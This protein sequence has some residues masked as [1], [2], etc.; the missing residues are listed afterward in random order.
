M[1]NFYYQLNFDGNSYT[2]MSY[3]G[4]EQDVKIPEVYGGRPVTVLFDKLFDGH[5]EIRS[6]TIPDVVTDMGEFI[7]D[8]CENITELKLPS[9]L[10]TLWGHTFVR[11]NIE[12]IVIPDGVISI[13]PFAFKDCRKL[14]KVV[15]GKKL[16]KIHPWAFG[17]CDSLKPENV[18][19]GP[20]VEISPDAFKYNEKK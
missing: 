10:Q 7:F 20:D 3:Q 14:K 5:K 4:D 2:A 6:V 8:G 15:C 13:P 12:E 16:K 17:G 1:Q 9:A 18:I 11:M 19:C